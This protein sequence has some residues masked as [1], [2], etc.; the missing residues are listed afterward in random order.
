MSKRTDQV[1]IGYASLDEADRE[2]VKKF[3]RDFDSAGTYGKQTFQES[4]NRSLN[5][6]SVGPR[7]T[8]ICGCCGRSQ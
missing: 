6:S 7:D 2:E 5:K 3:I 4:L 8:N 1:K